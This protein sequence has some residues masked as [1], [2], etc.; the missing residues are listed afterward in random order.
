LA[1]G[2]EVRWKIDRDRL[3]ADVS[4][5]PPDGSA[6]GARLTTTR[7]IGELTVRGKTVQ[8]EVL[9]AMDVLRHHVYLKGWAASLGRRREIDK[10]LN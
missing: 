10:V 3:A 4:L 2:L 5:K 7:P 6:A 9:A 1:D 8:S